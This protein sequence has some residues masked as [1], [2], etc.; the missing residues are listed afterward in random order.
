MKFRDLWNLPR[1]TEVGFGEDCLQSKEFSPFTTGPTWEVDYDAAVRRLHPWR[2]FWVQRVVDPIYYGWHRLRRWFGEVLHRVQCV[3][4]PSRY[5]FY[6]IDISNADPRHPNQWGYC[7]ASEQIELA[8]WGVLCRFVE[9]DVMYRPDASDEEDPHLKKMLENQ[10]AHYDEV[11]E[12]YAY[13]TVDRLADASKSNALF[14]ATQ[15]CTDAEEHARAVT[16]WMQFD[17]AVLDR[18]EEMLRRLIA[19][20]PGLWS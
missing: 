18:R 20:R 19:V 17:Q 12:L 11:Q 3:V 8:C 5:N 1:P 2:Y 13:W 14:E 16:E 4:W 10:A 6:R 9:E 15:N 7:D